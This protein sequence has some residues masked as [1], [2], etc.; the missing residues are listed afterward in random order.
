MSDAT[1]TTDLDIPALESAL[2]HRTIGHVVSTTM[3]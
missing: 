2:A 1:P 3:T